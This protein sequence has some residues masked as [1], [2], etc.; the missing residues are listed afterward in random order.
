[1][2]AL[3]LGGMPTDAVAVQYTGE[4][5]QRCAHD[6]VPYFSFFNSPEA[7]Y[8]K[9]RTVSEYLDDWTGAVLDDRS[10]RAAGA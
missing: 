2:T 8:C 5:V 4:P 1:M 10:G 9:G 3:D 7:G 6:F